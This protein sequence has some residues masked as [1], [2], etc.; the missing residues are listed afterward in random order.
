[1]LIII[2]FLLYGVVFKERIITKGFTFWMVSR[3][4]RRGHLNPSTMAGIH[5][6]KGAAPILVKS[7]SKIK[8]IAVGFSWVSRIA[9]KI[10]KLDATAWTRK[11]LRALSELYGVFFKISGMKDSM[12]SSMPTQTINQELAEVVKIIDT[13]TQIMNNEEEG[14]NKILGGV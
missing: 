14:W 4:R 3:S 12:F 11:Y 2:I 10:I 8:V 7:A 9:G 1:M 13:A 5:W 6:W